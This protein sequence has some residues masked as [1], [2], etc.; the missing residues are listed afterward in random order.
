LLV[1]DLWT[2]SDPMA[3]DDCVHPNDAGAR[4]MGLNWFNALKDVLPRD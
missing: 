4:R 1:A 3:A 2:N